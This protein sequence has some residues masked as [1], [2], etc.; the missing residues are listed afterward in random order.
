MPDHPYRALVV[1][2]ETLV[3]NLTVRALVRE[4]FTCDTAADGAQALEMV[5]RTAYDV[6]VT[7]LR[8]PNRH[9]HA[10]ACDVLAVEDHPAVVVLTGV[11]EPKLAKD[12]LARGVDHIE[13]KPVDYTLFAAKVR[14]LVGRR[15]GQLLAGGSEPAETSQEGSSEEAEAPGDASGPHGL[16]DLE[17]KL[18]RLC[19]ILPVSHAALDVLSLTS[20][21]DAEPEQ[22][23][24]AVARDPSLSA[25]VLKQANSSY[26]NPSGQ[27]I[28]DLEKAVA[29][30]GNKRLG[31]LAIA[32]SALAAL[33]ARNLPWMDVDLAWR[34]SVAAGVA[35]DLLLGRDGRTA[36][37]EGV[38]LS[39]IMHPLGRVVLGMLY[40]QQ[41]REMVQACALRKE[42]LA[43]LERS[44]LGLS[45][46][47]VISRL[48]ELWNVPAAVHEPLKHVTDTYESLAK[49]PEPL[50]T[51]T[52]LVKLAVLLGRIA[53]GYWEPWDRIEI[54][55]GPILKR[56]NLDSLDA[57]LAQVRID[58]QQIVAL[59]AQARSVTERKPQERTLLPVPYCNLSPEPFDFVAEIVGSMGIPLKPCEPDALASGEPVLINCVWTPVYRL[60]AHVGLGPGGE[61]L[62][63]TDT[64]HLEPYSRF[65]NVVALPASCAALRSPCERLAKPSHGPT[66]ARRPEPSRVSGNGSQLGR[67]P[68]F[69]GS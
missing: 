25:D 20:S 30:I 18:V 65:S 53:V 66:E 68:R 27:K 10:L 31:E 5:R 16:A 59:S 55:P 58:S 50:R 6:V 15:R 42:M 54:P 62:V 51:K 21:P 28:T 34:R 32:T 64:N 4:G 11:A 45:H 33:T 8:M 47:R 35:A 56:L 26:Y 37:D 61:R 23:A 43:D 60:A 52:E 57:I 69:C 3:R 24:A 49:L 2:D 13:F 63:I 14:G 39:A 17:A 67:I 19:R 44:T 36:S 7:D 29:R 12:L 46:G 41:Y 1:D 48:L 22:I 38:F 9:G 40:P